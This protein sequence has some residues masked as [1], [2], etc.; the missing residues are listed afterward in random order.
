MNGKFHPAFFHSYDVIPRQK[1]VPVSEQI[2]L[3]DFGIPRASAPVTM[4]VGLS[5]QSGMV[6]QRGLAARASPGYDT[7]SGVSCGRESLSVCGCTEH[8]DKYAAE[9]GAVAGRDSRHRRE[10][11]GKGVH[12]RLLDN[13]RETAR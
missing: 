11:A 4:E 3:S 8:M 12:L 7:R 13:P 1:R 6:S 10:P 9:H 2:E 5:F